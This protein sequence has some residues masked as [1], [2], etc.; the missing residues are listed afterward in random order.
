MGF[1]IIF[2]SSFAIDFDHFFYYIYK[3]RKLSLKKSFE[4]YSINKKLFAKMSDKEKDQIFTGLCFLHGIEAMIILVILSFIFQQY[5]DIF[6]YILVG[7]LFHHVLDAID[8][9]IRKYRFEKV[10][11]FIYSLRVNKSRKL[12]QEIKPKKKK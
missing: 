11:S 7:F 9:Y 5:S 12:L 3:T 2:I 10:I 4:W 6:M 8:L 1:F